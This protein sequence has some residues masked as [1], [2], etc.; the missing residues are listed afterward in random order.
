MVVLK[1][2]DTWDVFPDLK[3]IPAAVEKYIARRP[4]SNKKREGG[5]EREC[6]IKRQ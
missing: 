5:G 4:C 1:N 6:W 2:R 3:N